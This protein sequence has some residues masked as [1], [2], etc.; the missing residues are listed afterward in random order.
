MLTSGSPDFDRLRDALNANQG[1]RN[2]L[3]WALLANVNRI[4]P[5]D[6][7]NRFGSGA[8]V[9]WILASL[10]YHAGILA[11][12]GGHNTDGFDLRDLRVKAQGLWS[13]K[14]TTRRS[15]FRLTNGM[16]G[17]GKGFVDPVLL[18]SPALPGITFADPNVHSDLVSK[19]KNTG[20]ATVLPFKSAL[21]HA[22]EHPECVA[23]CR[24]PENQNE[25][26]D[27]PWMDYV[28]SLL[29][30]ERFPLLSKMFREAK[31]VNETIVDAIERLV[32]LRDSGEITQSQFSEFLEKL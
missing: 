14:N 23:V 6:R 25:G 22:E 21:L 27:D 24:M 26:Q 11:V 12:P 30:P 13:V 9:E 16:G 19:C 18:L 4:N 2:E 3:E 17:A 7:A 28:K 5:S 10:A 32:S 1:L 29:D 15:D 31:L 8:A 20:D